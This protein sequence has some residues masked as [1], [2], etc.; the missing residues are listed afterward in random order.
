MVHRHE[1]NDLIHILIE[2]LN[3]MQSITLDLFHVRL[4][5]YTSKYIL[6]FN[7]NYGY[8]TK[9][10]LWPKLRDCF[11]VWQNV[12]LLDIIGCRIVKL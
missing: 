3:D 10:Y 12:N 9:H 2:E 11:V 1:K 8:F 5:S 7:P 4:F 6:T